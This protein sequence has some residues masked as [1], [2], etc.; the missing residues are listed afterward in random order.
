MLYRIK[1]ILY[2]IC[3]KIIRGTILLENSNQ[4]AS[5]KMMLST[6]KKAKGTFFVVLIALLI[7]TIFIS[8]YTFYADYAGFEV[9]YTAFDAVDS[10][11]EALL[12][13]TATESMLLATENALS[14]YSPDESTTTWVLK[15]IGF[16]L[17]VLMITF[18]INFAL[19]MQ[20][21]KKSDAT[22]LV[23]DSLKRIPG[24]LFVSVFFIWIYQL[25]YRMF[26]SS[27]L[28]VPAMQR[29]FGGGAAAIPTVITAV[30]L[31]TL[32]ASLVLSIVLYTA[33]TV[34]KRRTQALFA[35]SYSRAITKGKK[36]VFKLIPW[37][38]V[39]FSFP[40]L[41][42]ALAPFLVTI[43][44]Y[45]AVGVL[46]FSEAL[47]IILTMLFVI[48]LVPRHTAFEIESDILNKIIQAQKQAFEAATGIKREKDD[49]NSDNK[50]DNKDQDDKE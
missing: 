19:D 32:L 9:N 13:G 3:I 24:M 4:K 1:K 35:L 48:Y 30:A 38:L 21:D 17:K 22:A 39:S 41:L 2:Y 15:I 27:M 20:K 10:S 8:G 12:S 14:A 11:P 37:V 43:N 25:A 6:I 33:I 44:H 28:T 45:I 46:C 5:I 47:F 42:N 7:P 49:K 29:I 40:L 36:Q 26:F 34:C 23:L 31:I 18:A 16:L 50:D